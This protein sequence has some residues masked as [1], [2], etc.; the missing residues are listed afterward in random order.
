MRKIIL[1]LLGISLYI[2]SAAQ[3]SMIEVSLSQRASASSLVVEGKVIA[4]N[5]F[6]NTNNTMIYTSNIIEVYKIFKG[7]PS[8][9]TIEILTEGGT[10]GLNK[11]TAEPTLGLN[12]DDIGVFTCIPVTRARFVPVSRNSYP[13]YEAYASAQ[14]FIKYNVAAQSASDVFRTYHNIESEVYN[15]VGATGYK[16]Y[17]VVKPFDITGSTNRN[18]NPNIQAPTISSFTPTTV[19][20]GTNTTITI[21][22][23]GFG[24]TQGSGTVG[25]KN[26]DDGGSTYINPLATQI[27]SWSNTSIT[28]EVPSNAG[29]GT[30]QVTQGST[31]TSASTLTVSWAH[32]NV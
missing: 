9:T 11:I 14:G 17:R 25:F 24:A 18:G 6:W 15:V 30:I 31:A 8:V 3:C 1:S 32:L 12:V 16:H 28:V 4:Q 26:A 13:R 22:G 7:D 10:V 19:T 20:A 2:A 27:I 23:S 21:S 5:S 29:T